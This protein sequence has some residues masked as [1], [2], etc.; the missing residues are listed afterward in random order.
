MRLSEIYVSTQGEGPKVGL[1]TVFI[2][3]AGCNLRCPGWP[4]DT[5]YAIDPKLYRKEWKSVTVAELVDQ[6]IRLDPLDT[7]PNVC[8]TGGEPF[9]QDGDELSKL[10]RAIIVGLGK[11]V[12][13]FSNGTI[14]YP[15]WTNNIDVVMDCKLPGSGEVTNTTMLISN[16]NLLRKSQGNAIKFTVFD[17]EDFDAAIKLWNLFPRTNVPQLQRMETQT[18][19]GPVWEK[20][21]PEEVA[22]WII[23]AGLPWRL[24]LQTHKLVYGDRRSV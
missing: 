14:R 9:L 21:P 7:I 3:F 11:T 5:P 20:V 13:A 23:E 1:P 22:A 18:F 8:L 19:C 24:N 12:E 16:Y 10:C 15:E 6:I 17:R 2:R 4:C